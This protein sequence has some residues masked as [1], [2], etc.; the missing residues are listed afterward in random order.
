MTF[1]KQLK[2]WRGKR[3]QLQ[4][5]KILKVKYWTFVAW[6]NGRNVPGPK[7]MKKVGATVG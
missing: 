4:A 2:R 6:E 7:M 5:A 1:K 3:T